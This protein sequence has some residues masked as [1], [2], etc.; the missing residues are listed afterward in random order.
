MPSKLVNQKYDY[1]NFWQRGVESFEDLSFYRA[2]IRTCR[3]QL[4]QNMDHLNWVLD[5]AIASK[6]ISM[7]E[8]R[9]D[10]EEDPAY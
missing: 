3:N 9:G 6:H 8:W 5:Y 4:F 10:L 1:N 2:N 7:E